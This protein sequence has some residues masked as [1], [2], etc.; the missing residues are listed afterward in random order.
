MVEL[1]A[2]VGAVLRRTQQVDLA[3]HAGIIEEVT[4]SSHHQESDCSAQPVESS[5][6]SSTAPPA[7]G[8]LGH[9]FT[10]GEILHAA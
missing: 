7:Y 6:M 2:R 1:V 3:T 10:L 4:V 9:M 5:S 8:H